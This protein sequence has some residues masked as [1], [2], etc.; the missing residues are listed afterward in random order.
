MRPQATIVSQHDGRECAAQFGVE[1]LFG[2]GT[3]ERCEQEPAGCISL[4]DPVDRV[5]AEAANTV[6]EDQAAVFDVCHVQSS[7]GVGDIHR[8]R[9]WMVA[10]FASFRQFEEF[11]GE[12]RNGSL[13]PV[14]KKRQA[15]PAVSCS[16]SSVG[17]TRCQ[18]A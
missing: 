5:I 17:L 10:V 7:A 1:E 15:R 14:N 12:K 4:Q 8:A 3:L 16:L 11:E 6:V 9:C 13:L 18:P 2:G